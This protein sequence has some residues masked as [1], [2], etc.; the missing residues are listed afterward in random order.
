M[1]SYDYAIFISREDW[2]QSIQISF[3]FW[4]KKKLMMDAAVCKKDTLRLHHG[5]IDQVCIHI[6]WRIDK[7]QV[8][9]WETEK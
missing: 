9:S 6:V 7:Q 4:K 1:Q 5:H 2:L 3:L 8:S